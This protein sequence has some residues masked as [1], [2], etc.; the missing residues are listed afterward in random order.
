MSTSK[1]GL[2]Q[3]LRHKTLSLA[4]FARVRRVHR[5]KTR[6]DREAFHDQAAFALPL[7]REGEIDKRV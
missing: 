2:T 1:Q 3:S 4:R 6:S 7:A 5:E